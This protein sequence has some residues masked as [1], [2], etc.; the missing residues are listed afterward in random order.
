MAF[1]NLNLNVKAHLGGK[2]GFFIHL[3]KNKQFL[4]FWFLLEDSVV[5][6]FKNPCMW[7]VHVLVQAHTPH[8]GACGGQSGF[9]CLS[10]LSITALETEPHY[11]GSSSL[12][13]GWL[14][15]DEHWGSH[16]CP[17]LRAGVT[18]TC[19]HACFYVG[20]GVPTLVLMIAGL[21]FLP[22]ELS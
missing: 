15:I 13:L 22:I 16:L 5:Q 14:E 20:D 21:A 1:R 3:V 17:P 6:I 8:C 4:H 12:G 10:S 9:G 2:Y 11:I 19:S 18:G 7:R